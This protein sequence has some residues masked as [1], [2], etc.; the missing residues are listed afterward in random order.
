MDWATSDVFN[1]TKA[2]IL[3][4]GALALVGLAAL[5]ATARG[6]LPRW[7]NGFE[8]PVLAVLAWTAASTVAL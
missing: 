7:E 4:A 1:L 6:R 2:T 3:V 5:D 8:W